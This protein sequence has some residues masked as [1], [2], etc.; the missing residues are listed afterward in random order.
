MDGKNN[1]IEFRKNLQNLMIKFRIVFFYSPVHFKVLMYDNIVSN[2][3]SSRHVDVF[4]HDAWPRAGQNFWRDEIFVRVFER[5]HS[6]DERFEC[7]EAMC[8]GKLN[9]VL[10]VR[11]MQLS[12]D[13]LYLEN[14]NQLETPSFIMNFLRIDREDQILHKL[15]VKDF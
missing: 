9:D 2:A 13:Q 15:G 5:M 11:N 12:C 8:I 4:L 10:F 6:P 1:N 3:S 14:V 7:Y